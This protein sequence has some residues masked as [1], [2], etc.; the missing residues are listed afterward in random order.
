MINNSKIIS[1]QPWHCGQMIRKLRERH[2][3][4]VIGLGLDPHREIRW[5]YDNSAEAY[6]WIANRELVGLGGVVGTL[7]ASSGKIWLALSESATRHPVAV[8]REAVRQIDRFMKTRDELVT[9]LLKDD[10]KSIKFA[11]CIGFE[12]VDDDLMAKMGVVVMRIGRMP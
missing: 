2:R 8:A 6:A 4:S 1:A 9:T 7:A 5:A 11:Y 12:N 10:A 3:E